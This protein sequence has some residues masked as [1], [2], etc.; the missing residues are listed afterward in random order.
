MGPRRTFDLRTV[1]LGLWLG[2]LLSSV[3]HA[4]TTPA[5]IQQISAA[6]LAQH[7][8][9]RALAL[10]SSSVLVLDQREAIPLY[11]LNERVQRPIASLTKVM[12]AIVT[13]DA[14]LPMD[15]LV[16]I[17]AADRDTLRGSRSRIPI[18]AVL[19]RRDLLLASLAASDNRAAAALAR[20]Y[21]GGRAAMLRAMNAK[22]RRLG[23]T[24]THYADPAGLDSG[25]VSTAQDLALMM[26]AAAKY[27]SVRELSTTGQFIVTDHRGRGRTI[28]LINTNRLVRSSAWEIGL[29]KTGYI[30]EAGNCLVMEA[31]IGD[32][33][34][35]IVLL[36]SWG[37]LSKYGDANRIRD[38]LLKSER[39]ALVA[40]VD[41]P[42]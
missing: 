34:V 1:I 35:V 10:R 15:E 28:E 24:H 17:V 5:L 27:P 13:L 36:N 30:S 42:A 18:G 26:L 12:T 7:A 2:C 23:M 6:E 39:R 14:D 22:A 29:S 9:A 41:A 40:K 11:G 38:W 21:P 25:S 3:S 20:T 33:P 32:R 31:V 19:S 8:S 37:K 16:T 4:E